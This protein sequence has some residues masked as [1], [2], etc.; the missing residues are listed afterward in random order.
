MPLFP[1]VRPFIHLVTDARMV[2]EAIGYPRGESP[3]GG[4]RKVHGAGLITIGIRRL[5][6]PPDQNMSAVRSRAPSLRLVSGVASCRV[7][8]VVPS[9]IPDSPVCQ[10]VCDAGLE[11]AQTVALG[12]LEQVLHRVSV[13]AILVDAS[14][15]LPSQ[16]TN[17]AAFRSLP[18]S[19][20]YP[21][22]V[23]ADRD[24]DWQWSVYADAVLHAPVDPSAL[25]AIVTQ[26]VS[27]VR[28]VVRQLHDLSHPELS[29]PIEHLGTSLPSVTLDLLGHVVDASEQV[30]AQLGFSLEELIGKPGSSFGHG[31]PGGFDERK[32][33]WAALQ[34]GHSWQGMML[35][36]S[37]TGRPLA[38][39]TVAT[40]QHNAAGELLGYRLTFTD[41]SETKQAADEANRL[42]T[43]WSHVSQ[44]GDICTMEWDLLTGMG[45]W[46]DR[47]A[48]LF[49]YAP[50][51][52][53]PSLDVYLSSLIGEERDQITRQLNIALETGSF[54]EVRRQLLK[55]DG[56]LVP[57]M[58]RG[59]VITKTPDNTQH[60]FLVVSQQR[61]SQS[62]RLRHRAVVMNPE[63]AGFS[64]Y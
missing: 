41:F 26:R 16:A 31:A 45:Q 18:Q 35:S 63:P 60:F 1:H 44:I 48:T 17:F 8:V 13:D 21:V 43:L 64:A 9:S 14:R 53:H 25:W 28:R 58:E 6:P 19:D 12:Q 10:L 55:P 32:A 4:A 46:S 56:G 30:C 40:P 57:V 50:G 42:R 29:A 49:G 20:A 61:I 38:A 59:M 36:Q 3:H 23:V 34:A 7:L 33:M 54:Y 5:S 52:T 62:G 51:Q 11:L 15:G 27:R 24:A 47:A 2:S 39:F 22:I 37:K